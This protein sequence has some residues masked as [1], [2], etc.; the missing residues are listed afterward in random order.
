MLKFICAFVLGIGLLTLANCDGNMDSARLLL[1]DLVA[2]DD[3]SPLK[4]RVRYVSHISIEGLGDVY[5]TPG[6]TRRLLFLRAWGLPISDSLSASIAQS[7]ARTGFEVLIPA[8]QSE[9]IPPI[10]ATSQLK[11]SMDKWDSVTGPAQSI[12]MIILAT[13]L[14]GYSALN[15]AHTQP[16]RI[17]GIMLFALPVDLGQ[18]ARLL[19]RGSALRAPNMDL[20]WQAMLSLI[21]QYAPPRDQ[22]LASTYVANRLRGDSVP[23]PAT[24]GSQTQAILNAAENGDWSQVARSEALFE[25]N[26]ISAQ[27]SRVRIMALYARN[28]P[29]SPPE[30]GTQLVEQLGLDRDSILVFDDLVGMSQRQ[31]PSR[32]DRRIWLK[33]LGNLIAWREGRDR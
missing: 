32:A 31:T 7:L 22:G 18:T 23:I 33:A 4:A 20:V 15:L 10:D 25:A 16:E 14:S 29:L 3:A 24:V 17:A 27:P 5:S 21:R 19:I 13:S 9:A 28:D 11:A 2:G 8:I 12:P 6:A 30:E 1:D 26:R